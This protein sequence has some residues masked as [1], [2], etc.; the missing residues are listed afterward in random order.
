MCELLSEGR[1]KGKFMA[2]L[3]KGDCMM[4]VL[5]NVFLIEHNLSVF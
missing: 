2:F 4:S 5:P 1:I 3:V